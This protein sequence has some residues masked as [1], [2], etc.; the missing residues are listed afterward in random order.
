MAGGH[1]V[2]GYEASDFDLQHGTAR[3]DCRANSISTIAGT[4]VQFPALFEWSARTC[5]GW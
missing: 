1:I 5:N 4:P 3:R 2:C